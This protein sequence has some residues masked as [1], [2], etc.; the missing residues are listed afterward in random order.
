MRCLFYGSFSLFL[1]T[2]FP[3]PFSGPFFPSNPSSGPYFY[4][5]PFN[6]PSFPAAASSH[7]SFN[8]VP[9]CGGLFSSHLHRGPSF[10]PVS[11]SCP[12][13]PSVPPVAPFSP[14]LS[15][16]SFLPHMS[17]RFFTIRR[18][19]SIG[20]FLFPVVP[21]GFQSH[22]VS[23]SLLQSVFFPL[24]SRP[25]YSPGPSSLTPII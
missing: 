7:S 11:F 1:L 6:G 9:P 14:H 3:E 23:S 4:L 17:R 12:S 13:F 2:L 10:Q 16:P 15:G 21:P 5:V 25:F 20:Y 18:H 22:L 8:P 19:V 24:P